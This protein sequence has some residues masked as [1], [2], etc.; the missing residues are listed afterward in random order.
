MTR[1]SRHDFVEDIKNGKKIIFYGANTL[2]MR[3]INMFCR[4]DMASVKYIVD[5]EIEKH[6]KRIY[7]IE[8]CSHEKLEKEDAGAVVIVITAAN[9]NKEILKT[10]MKINPDFKAYVARVLVNDLLESAAVELFDHQD[11]VRRVCD[12]LYDDESK[13]IY[14][15]VVK[16]RMQYG[17]ED[18]SDLIIT[19][20]MQY[21]I[22]NFFEDSIP[23]KEIIV[24]CG[25][26]TG[27][28]SKHFVDVFDCT[29][30]KIYAFECCKDQL[31][32]L[33]LFVEQAKKRSYCPEIIVMPYGV[34]DKEETVELY[35]T[36]NPGACFITE[37]RSDAKDALYNSSIEQVK[38]VS[39]DQ[40]IP[41]SEKV[42]L[43][44]MDI[45]GSEFRALMG[46]SRI[47]K[48]FKPRLAISIYHSGEDYYKIPLL[49]K[50]MVPEYKF[51]VRHHKKNRYDT[52][53][54]CYI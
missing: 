20:D 6:G 50:E 15:E 53:L 41:D 36:K 22:P 28:T 3:F 10:L 26:F 9:R 49:I 27:D 4:K 46:A 43:I 31:D 12:M 1:Q 40:V 21:M 19:G 42:T 11:D 35:N 37:N 44:K 5:D 7:G 38:T 54:Y 17:E 47:I 33:N 29:V 39:L 48:T 2:L 51:L 30:E 8:L 23:E 14:S 18:F 13:R 45:E 52:D 16:R 32:E 34:S 25:A 24:D